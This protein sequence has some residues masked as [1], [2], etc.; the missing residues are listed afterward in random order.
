MKYEYKF[1][2]LLFSFFFCTS[3]QRKTNLEV[4]LCGRNFYHDTINLL[5]HNAFFAKLPKS[6]FIFLYF[7]SP[8]SFFN[9]LNL[10]TESVWCEWTPGGLL[11][12]GDCVLLTFPMRSMPSHFFSTCW[13]NLEN[14]STI[15]KQ[16]LG[17]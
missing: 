8:H 16:V 9:I 13:P 3:L 14:K 10:I 2:S 12:Q 7:F 17:I 15:F 11:P 5:V 4:L 6:L 1:D